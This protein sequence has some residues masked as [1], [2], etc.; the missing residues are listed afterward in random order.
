MT[1]ITDLPLFIQD[2]I[3]TEAALMIIAEEERKAYILRCG[4]LRRQPFVEGLLGPV[5]FYERPV[6]EAERAAH[7]RGIH[8]FVAA[9]ARHNVKYDQFRELETRIRNL[10]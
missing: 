9:A 8:P 1:A 2:R 5:D 6:S 10:R 7:D 4:A 3:R